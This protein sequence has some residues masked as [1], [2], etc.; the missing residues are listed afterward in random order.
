MRHRA[1]KEHRIYSWAELP[2]TV[3]TGD[4]LRRACPDPTDCPA[5]CPPPSGA[6]AGE[7]PGDWEERY[8]E[9]LLYGAGAVPIEGALLGAMTGTLT[10][11]IL[12][13]LGSYAIADSN[14]ELKLAILSCMVLVRH[15]QALLR[16]RW[17]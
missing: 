9:V 10:G 11:G 1:T 2:S 6:P 17:Y 14:P 16:T 13:M 4:R 15:R 5:L 3:V 12:A 7:A 8:G